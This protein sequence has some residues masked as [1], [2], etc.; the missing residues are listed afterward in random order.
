MGHIS[1]QK[2]IVFFKTKRLVQT[3]VE[4]LPVATPSRVVTLEFWEVQGV[5]LSYEKEFPVPN[6]KW[7][8]H[9]VK[10]S[11]L[12]QRP[13]GKNIPP[14]FCVFVFHFH[15]RKLIQPFAAN[16]VIFCWS[17]LLANLQRKFIE[18]IIHDIFS[19]WIGFSVRGL[20]LGYDVLH[21]CVTVTLTLLLRQAHHDV[22]WFSFPYVLFLLLYSFCLSTIGKGRKGKGLG[23]GWGGARGWE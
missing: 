22:L 4:Q 23:R 19:L 13:T 20:L 10:S 17:D 15:A 9:W 16:T 21:T 7:D 14:E 6:L 5:F 1:C 18:S 2:S 8:F 12:S 11:V 3:S